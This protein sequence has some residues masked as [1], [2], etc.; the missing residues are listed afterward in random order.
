MGDDLDGFRPR[1]VGVHP[2]AIWFRLFPIRA[3]ST[4]RARSTSEW[5][6]GPGLGALDGPAAP[7]PRDSTRP[8][9]LH[10]PLGA[11]GLAGADFHPDGSLRLA[12]GGSSSGRGF[13]GD[14][15]TPLASLCP[16]TKEY[17]CLLIHG[18]TSSDILTYAICS[19]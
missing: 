11:L 4:T 7:G 16:G 2:A 14:V 1:L 10:V 6:H 13:Q 15:Q 17:A 3:N 9:R 5:G 8:P 12:H 19:S 18:Q